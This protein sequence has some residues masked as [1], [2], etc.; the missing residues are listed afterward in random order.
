MRW[1][2]FSAEQTVLL[3]KRLERHPTQMVAVRR[4][5]RVFAPAMCT[6]AGRD[7]APSCT[8]IASGEEREAMAS[9]CEKTIGSADRRVCQIRRHQAKSS[10]AWRESRFKQG[11][12]E[13]CDPRYHHL[14]WRNAPRLK[15]LFPLET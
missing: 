8:C 13:T 4:T 14:Q 12:L 3:D 9:R 15:R 7:D 5:N 1:R 10:Q 2:R 11:M 6:C